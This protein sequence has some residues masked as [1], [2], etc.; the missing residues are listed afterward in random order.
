MYFKYVLGIINNLDLM[1]NVSKMCL[2]Q[3]KLL[4]HFVRT[5]APTDLDIG[6]PEATLL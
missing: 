1:E 5:W 2:A 6:E 4:C 3:M